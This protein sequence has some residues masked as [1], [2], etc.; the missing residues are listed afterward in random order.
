MNQNLLRVSILATCLFTLGCASKTTESANKA[1]IEED[2]T[3]DTKVSKLK[4]GMTKQQVLAIMGDD[5]TQMGKG[6][7]AHGSFEGLCYT[8]N[9]GRRLATALKRQYTLGIAGRNDTTVV[10]LQF[11]NGLLSTINQH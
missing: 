11:Q 1:D 7:T 2:D 8:P 9:Y 6:L 3:F 4:I 10:T 5:Y